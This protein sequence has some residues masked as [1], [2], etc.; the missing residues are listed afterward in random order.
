MRLGKK[1]DRPLYLLFRFCIV[2]PVMFLPPTWLGRG[3]LG[4]RCVLPSFKLYFSL[5]SSSTIATCPSQP[6]KSNR[7]RLNNP[8]NDIVDK[9]PRPVRSVVQLIEAHVQSHILFIYSTRH[10][11]KNTSDAKKIETIWQSCLAL[12]T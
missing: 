12:M 10:E 2:F 6:G 7:M 8:R 3:A 1:E 11:N 4:S 5:R 9:D